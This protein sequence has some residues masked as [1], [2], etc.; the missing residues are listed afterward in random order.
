MT[1]TD[2]YNIFVDFYGEDKVDLQDNNIIVHFPK[3]T[4]TN[5][6]DRSID[7]YNLF[8]KV[9][10]YN[11]GY[12]KDT[13]KLIKST[14]TTD[15]LLSGYLHSHTPIVRGNTILKWMAPCMGSGPI[16]DTYL[17]LLNVEEEPSEEM[18]KLFCLEL[19]LYVQTESIE[20]IPYIR[21]ER[22]GDKTGSPLFLNLAYT[23]ED[24][25]V[26]DL[27]IY[28]ILKKFIPYVISKRP[29][30]FSYTGGCYRIANDKRDLAFI[31][32][33]LFIDWYNTL[34]IKSRPLYKDLLINKIL[35]ECIMVNNKLFI[36]KTCEVI[37][38]S[39]NNIGKEVLTFKEKSYKLEVILKQES[40]D[41]NIIR[42]LS[43]KVLR[44]IIFKLLLIVNK[45]YGKISFNHNK[46]I[47]YI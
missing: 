4:I 44:M 36:N 46:R 17:T 2:V 7:I 5:E 8:V 20:G 43:P 24:E 25:Y 21:L 35:V 12:I 23:P 19:S 45:E 33:N 28:S 37:T 16:K 40:K 42:V 9:P 31:L 32:S 47:R 26:S 22:V 6:N 34:P 18:W 14:Y 3:V 15:Q 13:F 1:L 38:T 27:E 29:F 39:N 11:D 10:V 41:D 30:L